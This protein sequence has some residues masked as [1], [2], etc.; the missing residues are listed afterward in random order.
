[1]AGHAHP[2]EEIYFF[3]RGEGIVIVGSEERRV[4]PGDGVEMAPDAYH[5]VRSTSDSHLPWFALW[6]KPRDS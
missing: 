5:T 1:M 4:Q 3:H 2:V 6:R